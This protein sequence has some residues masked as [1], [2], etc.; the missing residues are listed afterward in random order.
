MNEFDKI[1]ISFIK[2]SVQKYD[3]LPINPWPI[4][5]FVIKI[6]NIYLSKYVS[7]DSNIK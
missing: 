1:P 5:Q 4:G 3:V 7:D 2:Q 6:L